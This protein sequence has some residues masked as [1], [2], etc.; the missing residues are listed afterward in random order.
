MKFDE[1]LGKVLEIF[2]EALF[3]DDETLRGTPLFDIQNKYKEYGYTQHNTKIWKT[4]T[5]GE[6]ITN[7]IVGFDSCCRKEPVLTSSNPL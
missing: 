3:H 4:T 2:P 1:M 6:K 7:Y 5:A